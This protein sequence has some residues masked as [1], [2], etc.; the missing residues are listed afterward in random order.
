MKVAR[1]KEKGNNK[2]DTK[3]IRDKFRTKKLITA[4]LPVIVRTSFVINMTHIAIEK[5]AGYNK[6]IVFK[7]RI[8]K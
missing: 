1:R 6:A 2:I 5:H 3:E 4:F 7:K 8:S